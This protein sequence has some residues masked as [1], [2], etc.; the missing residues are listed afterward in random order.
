MVNIFWV[1]LQWRGYAELLSKVFN[2]QE[3]I[4]LANFSAA[5]TSGYPKRIKE[6][7][8]KAVMKAIDNGDK[9]KF[10]FL[11]SPVKFTDFETFNRVRVAHFN[12][13]QSVRYLP[14]NHTFIKNDLYWI[15]MPLT[16]ID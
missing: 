12:I 3:T 4:T 16:Y 5:M 13:E 14:I 6:A 10:P 8:L 11:S 2:G 1:L 15:Y 7:I 9:E